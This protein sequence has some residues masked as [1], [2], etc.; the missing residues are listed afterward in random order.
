MRNYRIY[1]YFTF[2]VI[3]LTGFFMYYKSREQDTPLIASGEV[4][5]VNNSK[6]DKDTTPASQEVKDSDVNNYE[7]V[8][9]DSDFVP[10]MDR[11]EERIIKKHFGMYITPETS[12][13]QPDKFLGYHTGVDWE[14]FPEELNRDVPVRAVCDGTLIL[15]KYATGYG[16]VGVQECELEGEPITVVYGHL[17]LVSIKKRTGENLKAG[18][19]IGH[20]GDD[21]SEETDGA[22]KHLHLAIHLGKNCELKGYI[23]RPELLSNW[24]DP[25]DYGCCGS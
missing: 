11:A 15:K 24:L 8:E 16:G 23:T 13:V 17:D 19:I 6:N 18:E 22:R 14:I 20:L 7:R 12:P 4:Q 1:I 21:K 5:E 2:I 10:P 25:C 3:L 9:S